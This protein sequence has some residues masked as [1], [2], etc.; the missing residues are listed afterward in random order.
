MG[1]AG[2]KSVRMRGT[3]VKSQSEHPKAI[4]SLLK[5]TREYAMSVNKNRLTSPALNLQIRE[6]IGAAANDILSRYHEH[7]GHAQAAAKSA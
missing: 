3:A 6:G 1:S 2:V 5:T 4:R 7:S